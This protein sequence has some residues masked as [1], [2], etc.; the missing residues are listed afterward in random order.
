MWP[1]QDVLTNGVGCTYGA[2]VVEAG[3]EHGIED[4]IDD[5]IEEIDES[6]VAEEYPVHVPFEEKLEEA[7]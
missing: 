7:S 3:I 2:V 1:S 6:L 5:G 4:G